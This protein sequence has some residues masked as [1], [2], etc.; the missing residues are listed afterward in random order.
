MGKPEKVVPELCRGVVLAEDEREVTTRDCILYALG[1]AA[2]QDPLDEGDLKYCYEG[3]S[4]GFSVLPTFPATLMPVMAIFEGL[5]KCPGLPAFNPMKLLHG[6]HKITLLKPL[7]P[8]VKVKNRAVL[9]DVQDKRS[10]A[11]VA[12]RVESF[13]EGQLICV[14]DF[15]LFIRGIGNFAT[16][17]SAGTTPAA[18][19]FP[20]GTSEMTQE[21]ITQPNLALI[22]RLS[23]DYNPLHADIELAK[24]GG[25]SRPI[26]HGL[27]TLGIATR[28]IIKEVLG[29]DPAK[30]HSISCRFTN[31]TTPGDRLRIHLW[32][33]R[34]N[35]IF[36]QVT[37]MS[38]KGAVVLD[39]GIMEIK[40]H[41][42]GT[43]KL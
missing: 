20:T 16:A 28:L 35:R 8:D 18:I 10:G 23:G 34:S 13:C 37:N 9:V 4:Q 32:G 33:I 29:N 31:P 17:P 40:P 22:Y 38:R 15:N 2:C 7:E 11:L 36:F 43:S 27:C 3:S 25:F 5:E 30:V 21:V 12:I 39:K 6:E 42:A 41:S 19:K 24:M 1:T 26:L 14:N